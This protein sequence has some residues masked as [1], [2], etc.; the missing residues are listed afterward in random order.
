M[1]VSVH[2]QSITITKRQS[3]NSQKFKKKDDNSQSNNNK[4]NVDQNQ[5][6]WKEKKEEKI[7]IKNLK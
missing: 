5:S 2:N 4:E 7:K 6:I 3:V 1:A